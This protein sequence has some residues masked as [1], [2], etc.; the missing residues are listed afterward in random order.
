MKFLLCWL[1]YFWKIPSPHFI[2]FSLPW[3]TLCCMRACNR[4]SFGGGGGT[5]VIITT[6][7]HY[8]YFIFIPFTMPKNFF[9]NDPLMHFTSCIDIHIG[10]IHKEKA[11]LCTMML[12][13]HI[14]RLSFSVSVWL[15]AARKHMTKWML[16]TQ[17]PTFF[18]FMVVTQEPTIR[19]MSA[20]THAFHIMKWMLLT[21]EPTFFI[22]MVVTQEPTIRNAIYYSGISHP[23]NIHC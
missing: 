3:P 10:M 21:Q 13:M 23:G 7:F 22:F 1:E 19:K 11:F 2:S 9:S 5:I 8:H 16:L 18:T 6:F 20:V 15:D 14:N 12:S 17:E 4:F